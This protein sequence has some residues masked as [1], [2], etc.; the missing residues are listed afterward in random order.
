MST[1]HFPGR[2]SPRGDVAEVCIIGNLTIDVIMRGIEEMPAWG[3]ETLSRTRTESVAGQAGNVAFACAAMGVRAEVVADVG[4]DV[5]GVRIRSELEAA[6]VGV[7]AVSVVPGGSSPLSVAVVR[8]DG[9]RAFISDLGRLRPVDI[10]AVVKKIPQVNQACVVALV[11][12]ANL[13]DIDLRAAAGVFAEARQAG[14]LTVFDPGWDPQGWTEKTVE[15]IR[16]VLA[17]TDVF[18][19]NLDEARALTGRSLA[20]EVLESLAPLCSGVVIVKGGEIGSYADVDGAVVLVEAI[21]TAVD[22]AV[23]AGD[24]YDAAVIA[25]YLRGCDVVKGMALG[26]AAASLYVSRRRDRFP[27]YEEA[28][29]LA[30]RVTTSTLE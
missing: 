10:A 7:Q 12:T 14:A 27:T 8:D 29:A 2:P 26:T 4:D 30:E 24:V 21:P 25:G 13:P 5:S 20:G 15:G 1:S 16:A 3:Q 19:P 11:G 23:G 6:G 18:L 22:N 9:E 17:Q 28:E